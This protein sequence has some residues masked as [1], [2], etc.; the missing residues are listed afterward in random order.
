MNVF[1]NKENKLIR[2]LDGVHARSMCDITDPLLLLVGLFA[3]SQMLIIIYCC[4]VDCV[5]ASMNQQGR[6]VIVET[7]DDDV[8]P[9]TSIS[10]V[11]QQNVETAVIDFTKEP[12]YSC[13]S[14]ND[15]QNSESAEMNESAESANAQGGNEQNISAKMFYGAPQKTDAL[16]RASRWSE[17]QR[18]RRMPSR[19]DK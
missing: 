10:S 13:E 4:C 12:Q 15:M 5:S 14:A 3:V 6:D 17:G 8:E 18:S 2:L 11:E 1:V 7:H 19:Y 16:V 9:D